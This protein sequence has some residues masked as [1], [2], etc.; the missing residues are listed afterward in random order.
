MKLLSLCLLLSGAAANLRTPVKDE[1]DSPCN[2]QKSK[3]SCFDTSDDDGTSC[4]WCSCKAV[5]SECLTLDQSKRVPPGVFQC[6]SPSRDSKLETMTIEENVVDD[7]FCD[8]NSKSGYVSIDKSSYDQDGEDK[9]LFYWMFQKRNSDITDKSIP[10]IV[11][12][13][14]GPGCSSSLA[15]LTENGPCTVNDDAKT[16]QLNPNSWT[17]SAH[18]LWL[19]QP[20]GV[21]FSYGSETDSNEEMISEDAYWFLQKF[22][23]ANPEFATNPLFIVGESYGGHYAPAISHRVWKYNKD[24]PTGA[25][26]LN[27]AGVAVGNGLTAPEEQYKVR[28]GNRFFATCRNLLILTPLF[29]IQINTVVPRNGIQQLAWDPSHQR[30][31]I[32]SHEGSRSK[33]S[34]P[35]SSMQQGR[36]HFEQFRLPIRLSRLQPGSHQ[37]LPSHWFEPI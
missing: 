27:L 5:P 6:S 23:D 18:V 37:S 2:A 25:I 7:D 9:N 26:G 22:F 12:L 13:T 3:N 34:S 17:E 4:V 10:F 16:T 1:G 15:L 28:K 21:G 32:R 29:S 19:D 31:R 35:H 14:G 30:T 8:A 20:A 33:V 36:F 24:L 11:W